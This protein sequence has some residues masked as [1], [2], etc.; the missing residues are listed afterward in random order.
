MTRADRWL[1]L[2]LL[3]GLPW[4]YWH[5]WSADQGQQLSIVAAGQVPEILPL[6]ANQD[7]HIQ[8]LLGESIIRIENGR[9]RFIHSP[10]SNKVCIQQGWI[11]TSGEIAAC[12]PNRVSLQVLGGD[13]RFDAVNF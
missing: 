1:I 10:C 3:A 4:L 12:L 2:L 6:Y 7:V 11:D 13:G 9:A 5:F 8:G